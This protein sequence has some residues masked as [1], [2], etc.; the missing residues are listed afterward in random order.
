[1]KGGG[2]GYRHFG[3]FQVIGNL[4]LQIANQDYKTEGNCYLF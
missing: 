4:G 3:G 1:M 2:T